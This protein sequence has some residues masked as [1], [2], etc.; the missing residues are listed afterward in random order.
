[1]ASGTRRLLGASAAWGL[2]FFIDFPMVQACIQLSVQIIFSLC[3]PHKLVVTVRLA[4]TI[5]AI[6]RLSPPSAP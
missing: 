2:D 5:P 6:V 4:G 3:C 1:V